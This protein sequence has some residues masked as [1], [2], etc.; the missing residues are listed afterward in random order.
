MIV[1]S[2]LILL[3]NYVINLDQLR[4]IQCAHIFHNQIRHI[5]QCIVVLQSNVI[6]MACAAV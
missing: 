5:F 1:Y 6:A 3:L 4:K 2:S